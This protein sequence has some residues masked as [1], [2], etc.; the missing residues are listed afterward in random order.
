MVKNKIDI[1][2]DALERERKA[3]K[4]AERILE[5]KSL[6]LYNKNLELEAAN[7]NLSKIIDNRTEEINSIL[8]NVLDSYILMDLEGN[9]LKM[10]EPAKALFG[11]DIDKGDSFNVNTIV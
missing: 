7:N 8:N 5:Q 6:E 9:V 11:F 10:N 2:H 3:R 4:Q 1:L